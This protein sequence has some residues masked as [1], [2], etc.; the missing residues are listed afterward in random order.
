MPSSDKI[1]VWIA[2]VGYI[3]G[4]VSEATTLNS[5]PLAPGGLD[6]WALPAGLLADD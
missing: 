1:S 2:H 4:L 3:G 5:P 6:L